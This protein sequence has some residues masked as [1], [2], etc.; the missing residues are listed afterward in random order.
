MVVE[1]TC[2]MF[3]ISQFYSEICFRFAFDIVI[4]SC[5]HGKLLLEKMERVC[6]LNFAFDVQNYSSLQ[7]MES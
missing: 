2:S 3:V 5:I 4:A 1:K 6:V 7:A